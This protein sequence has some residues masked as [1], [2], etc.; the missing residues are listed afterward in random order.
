MKFGFNNNAYPTATAL[1]GMSTLIS[2]INVEVGIDIER[3]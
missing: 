1:Y 3:V 2:L